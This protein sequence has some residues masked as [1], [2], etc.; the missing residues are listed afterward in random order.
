MEQLDFLKNTASESTRRLDFESAVVRPGFVNNTFFLFVSGTTPCV[1]MEV[2]LQPL[3]YVRC[4]EYWGIEVIG[5]L[6]TGICLEQI[7]HYHKM[8]SLSGIV[9]SEGIEVIGATKHEQIK[10]TGGC[11]AKFDIRAH[12]RKDGP[13]SMKTEK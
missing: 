2:A 3:I 11:S 10:V 1:N 6:P 9:G 4:P 5:W 12:L 13:F 7:G 8:I